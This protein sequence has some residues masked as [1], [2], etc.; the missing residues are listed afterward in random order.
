MPEESLV[1]DLSIKCRRSLIN[2]HNLKKIESILSTETEITDETVKVINRGVRGPYPNGSL[3]CGFNFDQEIIFWKSIL[4]MFPKN[5]WLNLIYAEYLVQKDKGYET[6][7]EFYNRAFEIDYRLIFA[8]E[9]SWRDELIKT[10]FKYELYYLKTQKD[11]YDN[12]DFI[13][14][15]DRLR[16]KYQDDKI[17][18]VEIETIANM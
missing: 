6:A 12:E 1:N 4:S 17:K 8:I 9:P 7:H 14:I 13:E 16:T 10:D 15:A 11:D 2:D 18:L 5:G 3:Y